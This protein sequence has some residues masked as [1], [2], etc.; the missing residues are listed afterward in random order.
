MIGLIEASRT[1]TEGGLGYRGLTL[2]N[3]GKMAGLPVEVRVF[4]GI[5]GLWENGHPTYYH[6]RNDVEDWL[7]ELARKRGHGALVDQLLE[8]NR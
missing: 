6:D 2:L 4:Q 3:P 8:N 7:I 5:L 1:L